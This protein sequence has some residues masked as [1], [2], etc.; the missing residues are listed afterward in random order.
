M[1]EYTCK[2]FI[3]ELE[4]E[5]SKG[6]NNEISINDYINSPF[7]GECDL[8]LGTFR[9]EQGEVK[10]LDLENMNVKYRVTLV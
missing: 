4:L 8:E 5:A 9:D 1:K 6:W 7:V 3:Y 2:D 10:I